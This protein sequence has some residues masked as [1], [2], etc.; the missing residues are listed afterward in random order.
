[1]TTPGKGQGAD[2]GSRARRPYQNWAKL[3]PG[4]PIAVAD[5]GSMPL[6]WAE[7]Y[8][9]IA[10]QVEQ[11]LTLDPEAKIL[12]ITGADRRCGKS[13]TS[14]NLSL[15]LARRG[16]RRVILVEGDLWQPTLRNYLDAQENIDGMGDILRR[17]VPVSQAIVSVWGA[18]LDVI[19]AGSSG[20]VSDLM[21][22]GSLAKLGDDL[23]R[24]YEI[25]VVDCPPVMLAAGR[26]LAGWVD[27]SLL[28]V[29][30]GQTRKKS[31]E[32]ALR[33]LGPDKTFGMIL[34]YAKGTPDSKYGYVSYLSPEDKE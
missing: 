3:K 14:L 19:F 26:S 30:A 10:V 21:T 4:K 2:G 9:S 16:E 27:K 18:G 11:S 25:I 23:R 5:Q 32:D 13:L 6:A 17:G 28:V 24:K 7:E 1:M 29:R 12:A 20:D 8:R 15:L 34:N 22:G 31:I 33:I